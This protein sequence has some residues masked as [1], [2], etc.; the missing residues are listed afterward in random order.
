MCDLL[1]ITPILGGPTSPLKSIVL[2]K[3]TNKKTAKDTGNISLPSSIRN[4]I[5]KEI[6]TNEIKKFSYFEEKVFYCFDKN[7]PIAHS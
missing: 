3:H 7:P 4:I 1:K 5:E 6:F 2:S